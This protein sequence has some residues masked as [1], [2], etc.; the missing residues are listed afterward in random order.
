[1]KYELVKLIDGSEIKVNEITYGEYLDV[2][3]KD[4]DYDNNVALVIACTGLSVERI[5]SMFKPDFN[6]LLDAVEYINAS[7]DSFDILTLS[8]T[9]T[10]PVFNY[11]GESLSV[12]TLKYP[13]VT[14]GRELSKIPVNQPVDRVNYIIKSITGITD[15]RSL[16]MSDFSLLAFVCPDFFVFGV[17]Y[18]RDLIKEAEEKKAESEQAEG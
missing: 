14:T 2:R 6:S 9:L 17:N 15:L 13:S 7:N 18:F 16:S 3:S 11:M 12:V 8:L 1:M 10:K 5:E 4:N